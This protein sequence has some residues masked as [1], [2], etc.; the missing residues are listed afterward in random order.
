MDIN[1]LKNMMKEVRENKKFLDSLSPNQFISKDFLI[2]NIKKIDILNSESEIVIFG[3]WYGSIIIPAFY[4]DV[5][6]ITAIDMDQK[7]ISIAKHRIFT[8]YKK[9]D[10]I[11]KDL[12]PWAENSSRIKKT[13][14]IINTSCEHMKPMKSLKILNNL[15]CYFAFQS[16]NMFDIEGHI[17]CVETMEEFKYQLPDNADI[18]IEDEVSD[19]RGTRFT[20]I[21]KLNEKSD[22]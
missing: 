1:L 16:N 9:I 15:N 12:F 13:D 5:K 18:I 8:D 22:L 19:S 21:G 20:V 7:V 14:L 17:N 10:F 6:R 2:K 11:A 3:C 4:N